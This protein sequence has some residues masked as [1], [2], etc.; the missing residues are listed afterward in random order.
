MHC[1]F[2]IIFNWW[3]KMQRQSFHNNKCKWIKSKIIKDKCYFVITL[4]WFASHWNRHQSGALNKR[5]SNELRLHLFWLYKRH[6]ICSFDYISNAS[7]KVQDDHITRYLN[8][9]VVYNYMHVRYRNT[10]LNNSHAHAQ[11]YVYLTIL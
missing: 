5:L 9:D 11:E 7:R 2:K 10:F 8:I 3:T 1:K 4:D 6:D